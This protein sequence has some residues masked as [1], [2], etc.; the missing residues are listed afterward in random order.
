[1]RGEP[2]QGA[3]GVAGGTIPISSKPDQEDVQA[4]IASIIARAVKPPSN[5]FTNKK[6]KQNNYPKKKKILFSRA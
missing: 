6:D 2:N 3:T 1:L 4:S 5:Y